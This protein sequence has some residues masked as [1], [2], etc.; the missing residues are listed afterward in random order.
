VDF[1]PSSEMLVLFLE[2]GRHGYL[3]HHCQLIA[4][5]STLPTALLNKT[6]GKINTWQTFK[7][8]AFVE[9]TK[10]ILITHPPALECLDVSGKPDLCRI[11]ALGRHQHIP[12]EFLEKNETGEL[13]LKYSKIL[14]EKIK[15]I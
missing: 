1:S 11:W 7:M 5:N 15:I 13:R 10:Y 3:L 6:H 12:S 9:V 4:R 14:M 2:L 8:R